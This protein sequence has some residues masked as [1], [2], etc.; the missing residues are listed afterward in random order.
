M[1]KTTL[2]TLFILVL[3][4]FTA[5]IPAAFAAD[6]PGQGRSLL[7]KFPAF[8]LN[9]GEKIAGIKVKTSQGEITNSCLPGRWR[10]DSQGDSL[11]CY[12]IHQ[13]FAIALTG[14]LPELFIRNIP[15]NVSQFSIEATVEY[16][17]SDGNAFSRE[18]RE[19]DL[20]IK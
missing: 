14:L 5:G 13:S 9:P 2:H 3:V 11:H 1:I 8:S 18:F 10:C 15:G 20:I 7:V 19:G 6:N 4:L 12:C 16:L 17:S